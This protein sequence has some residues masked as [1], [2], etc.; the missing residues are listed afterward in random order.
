MATGIFKRGDGQHQ[1]KIQ[2]KGYPKVSRTFD[3]AELATEWRTTTLADM[4][5]GDWMP[6]KQ[7]EIVT[8]EKAL[9][10]YA[11]E[12]SAMKKGE[13]QELVRIE[14]LK[15]R[16]I[17]KKAISAI[18]AEDIEDYITER[19]AEP[20][21]RD[22]TKHVSD[23][24]IRLEVMLLSAV[25]TACKSKRWNY[26]RGANPVSE[27]D[28]EFRL[29]KSTKRTRRFVGNEE[30]RLLAAL[31]KQCRN[32]DIPIVVRFATATAARQSELIGKSATTKR[33]ATPG[34][35]W[36][37][38][39]LKMRSVTF[40]DT[41][42]GHDRVVP[43]GSAALALLSALPR[44]IHGGKVF[45]V[46]QDGLIRAMQSACAAAEI[47]DFTFHDLRHEATSRMIEDGHPVAIVQ[48]ITGHSSAEMTERYTH[49][50]TLKTAMRMR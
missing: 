6:R 48:K 40:T 46:T 8:L 5:R 10:K 3:T 49:I 47:E 22:K 31:D 7:V 9:T 11:D 36:D 19:R 24:T 21:K 26:L 2:K 20:S 43:L 32:R 35:T 27:I 44:P 23:A 41:K 50:D 38:V 17:A 15:N 29:K 28:E 4:I 39:D 1:A 34:L 30:N 37:K 33:P 14:F 18:E 45:A 16:S 42:N 13:R 12:R 25:F